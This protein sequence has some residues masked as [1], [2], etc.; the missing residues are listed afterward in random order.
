MAMQESHDA[1]VV[2]RLVVLSFWAIFCLLGIPL[3]AYTTTIHRT[4]LPKDT[5]RP[6]IDRLEAHFGIDGSSGGVRVTVGLSD[7]CLALHSA[8]QLSD[9]LSHVYSSRGFGF[10]IELGAENDGCRYRLHCESIVGGDISK[11]RV[12][13]QNGSVITIKVPK[14]ASS[15]VSQSAEAIAHGIYDA[16]IGD[17]LF[18]QYHDFGEKLTATIGETG[19]TSRLIPGAPFAQ[20]LHISFTL[21]LEINSDADLQSTTNNSGDLFEY[22]GSEVQRAWMLFLKN[23]EIHKFVD[24]TFDSQVEL[25]YTNSDMKLEAR[26]YHVDDLNA[27]LNSWDLSDLTVPRRKVMQF[28]T[29]VPTKAGVVVK[30]SKTNSFTVA[31]WGGVVIYD[32]GIDAADRT[33]LRKALGLF[34][35]QQIRTLLA[36]VTFLIEDSA[37][38]SVRKRLPLPHEYPRIASFVNLRESL[39]TIGAIH[40]L[41]DDLPEMAVPESVRALVDIALTAWDRAAMFL[42]SAT[43]S[44]RGSQIYELE[45]AALN[46]SATASRLAYHALFDKN[47]MQNMF[48]PLEHK[49][50]VYLPLLG[51]VFIPLLAGLKRVVHDYIS[52][53]SV[54]SGISKV[55]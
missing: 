53:R 18:F 24:L 3:W 37:S 17:V 31:G 6:R 55:K 38:G 29:F 12:S 10:A 7:S 49:M 45:L 19:A 23:S 34:L 13:I 28:V 11:S 52:E 43:S 54:P 25:L 16:F 48:V 27:M 15:P 5:L 26:E 22:W 39:D 4:A 40:K 36:P 30:D 35:T 14:V 51:P 1:I 46:S 50:A 2:R 8:A 44:P 33:S 20:N 9:A 21:L 41:V 32:K 47:M 42:L